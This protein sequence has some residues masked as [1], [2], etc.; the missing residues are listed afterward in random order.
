MSHCYPTRNY[1]VL[2]RQGE[3]LLPN[4]C[5]YLWEVSGL[6]ELTHHRET[7]TVTAV[8][9]KRPSCGGKQHRVT[10]SQW[11]GEWRGHKF[12][13]RLWRIRE[14]M[15]WRDESFWYLLRPR[16]REALWVS[17]IYKVLSEGDHPYR[18]LPETN[19]VRIRR[20]SVWLAHLCV[21]S[22]STWDKPFVTTFGLIHPVANNS[23]IRRAVGRKKHLQW[24]K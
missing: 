9:Y 8:T 14:K 7:N 4:R 6:T 23:Y 17:L 20:V 24:G 11:S 16:C 15:R 22:D 18:H 21:C 2:S 10:Q 5:W 13:P 3:K 19:E 12:E 1:H